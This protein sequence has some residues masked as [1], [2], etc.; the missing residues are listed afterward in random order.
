MQPRK[1]KYK[2][3]LDKLQEFI[4][5]NGIPN[6]GV[7]CQ[8]PKGYWFL[9]A[10]ATNPHGR[11]SRQFIKAVANCYYKDVRGFKTRMTKYL[12]SEVKHI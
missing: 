9:A 8:P 10:K 6:S 4:V 7:S 3:D 2:V 12:Y 11:P 1:V 5:K